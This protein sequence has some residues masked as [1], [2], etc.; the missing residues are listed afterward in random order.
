MVPSP[1]QILLVDLPGLV[2]DMV[3]AA[4]ER[5]PDMLVVGEVAEG[6]DI[7]ASAALHDAEVV[8]VG[9]AGTELPQAAQ[10]LFE[11]RGRLKVIGIADPSCV[12]YIYRPRTERIEYGHASPHE[13]TSAIR[14][15]S[16]RM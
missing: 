15:A 1:I 12:A 13:L 3:A 11:R 5:E 4:V 9:L 6:D 14:V 10:E 16:G 2:R 8:I 7:G